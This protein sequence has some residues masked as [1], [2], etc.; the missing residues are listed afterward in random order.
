MSRGV[1]SGH[2]LGE[3]IFLDLDLLLQSVTISFWPLSFF[4][5]VAVSIAVLAEHPHNAH[6]HLICRKDL[7]RNLYLSFYI[8]NLQ[9]IPQLVFCTLLNES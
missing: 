4:A 6:L 5:N 2:I 1:H 7:Q 9:D 8:R 3:T